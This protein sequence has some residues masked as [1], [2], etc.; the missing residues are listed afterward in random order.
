VTIGRKYNKLRDSY[1][2]QAK[3]HGTLLLMSGGGRNYVSERQAA[4]RWWVWTATVEWYWQGKNENSDR[5]LPRATVSTTTPTWIEP[6]ANPGL[7]GE[8][9]AMARQSRCTHTDTTAVWR[10]VGSVMDKQFVMDQKRR[11]STGRQ[12]KRPVSGPRPHM[13][14]VP[15]GIRN[16]TRAKPRCSHQHLRN[17]IKRRH[18][19]R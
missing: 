8:G 15:A 16:K 11:R 6:G 9:P 4:P 19:C 2:L 12:S 10:Q 18:N 13:R 7:R 1:E 14:Q 3:A 17:D 5:N